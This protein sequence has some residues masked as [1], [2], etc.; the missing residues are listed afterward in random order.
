[1]MKDE[2]DAIT[3][4]LLPVQLE[5]ET[6]VPFIRSAYNYDTDIVSDATGLDCKDPSLAQQSAAEDAD[7]NTIVARFGLTGE[8]PQGARLPSYG[9]YAGITDYRAALAAIQEAD[10][11]FMQYPAEMRARFNNSPHQFMEFVSNPANQE[12]IYNLGLAERPLPAP[13]P[14]TDAPQAP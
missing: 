5:V 10:E 11:N 14:S 4:E 7:I 13:T 1:M 3:G 9:D 8:M 2:F 12:E 6:S